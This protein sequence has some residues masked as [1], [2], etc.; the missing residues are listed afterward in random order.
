M[1]RISLDDRDAWQRNRP[2]WAGRPTLAP[3]RPEPTRFYAYL[4]DADEDLADEFDLRM[5]IA[6]RQATTVRVLEAGV[7]ECD[8]SQSFARVGIGPGLLIIDGLIAY[9]T[10]IASRTAT[11]L[12]GAGDLLQPPAGRPHELLVRNGVWRVLWPTRFALLD[13]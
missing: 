2:D 4:L 12:I 10:C 6:A 7:G 9:E 1:V 3:R 8:L 13:G 5:R 11:E